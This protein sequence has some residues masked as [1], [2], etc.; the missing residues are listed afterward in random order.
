M[1][2]E[3]SLI[4]HVGVCVGKSKGEAFLNRV[5]G[6]Q[7]HERTKFFQKLQLAVV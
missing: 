5:L 4:A 2:L 1:L 7:K 6:V 3:L